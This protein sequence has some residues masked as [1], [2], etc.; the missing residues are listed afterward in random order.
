MRNPPMR[1]PR[2]KS[3]NT[4]AASTIAVASYNVHGCVGVDG[5]RDPGRVARVIEELNAQIYGLQ[6]VNSRLHIKTG[7]AD[8]LAE[9]TGLCEIPGPTILREDGHFGNVLLTSGRV[10][11]SEHLDLSVKGRE[12]RGAIDA[13]LE[14]EEQRIRI[15]VT[16]LGLQVAERH[17]QVK[18]LL[19]RFREGSDECLIV[20]GDI[21][22]WFPLSRPLRALHRYLGRAR[23]LRTYPSQFP[24]LPLDRIWV[25]P[26][27]SLQDIHAHKSRLARVASDHLPVKASLKPTPSFNKS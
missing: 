22:E 7:Q 3:S 15:I 17:Y 18:R 20:L 16:H 10:L 6:E 19:Q 25:R 8:D 9:M 1:R 4:G 24:L 12:P 21:N 27:R 14:V 13:V 2:D 5:R 23:A 11:R 26:K